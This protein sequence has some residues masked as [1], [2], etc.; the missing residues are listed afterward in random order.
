MLPAWIGGAKT[1][2]RALVGR[3]VQ[4]ELWNKIQIRRS[5]A[6]GYST[7]PIA[8]PGGPSSAD[9]PTQ[10]TDSPGCHVGTRRPG[11]GVSC[12]EPL[13][14]SPSGVNPL[15]YPA[16]CGQVQWKSP[17]PPYQ[18]APSLRVEALGILE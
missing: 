18:R 13:V 2:P 11:Q 10:S 16:R 1:L 9:S 17:P 3:G 15:R 8:R 12:P 5:C 6:L 14:S 7:H 4:K